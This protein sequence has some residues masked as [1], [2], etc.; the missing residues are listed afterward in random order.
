MERSFR[1]YILAGT[2]LAGSA[3]FGG[4]TPA[5]AG[6]TGA[7]PAV[8]YASL[9]CDLIITL[10][11]GGTATV[12][13]GP[14]HGL[15]GGTYDGV[16][17]TLIGLINDSGST[18]TAVKLTAK[19]DIF[20]FDGDGIEGNPNSTSGLPSFTGA[21]LPGTNTVACGATSISPNQGYCGTD[22]TN[23]NFNLSGPL[24]SFSGI[25]AAQDVGI[26]NFPGGI[27]NGG[28]AFWGL[29]EALTAASFTV[30]KPSVPE[31][32]TLSILG[33]ALAG[34]GMMRRRKQVT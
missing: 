1:Q 24:N 34:F 8:G 2:I 7:C 25:T 17:D 20:G 32:A 21:P 31:P 6:V 11:P 15:A 28:S 26:V 12:T 22:S 18:V 13:D 10:N 23:G 16:D 5:L 30:T 19:T 27:P 3:A 29:E 4:A 9:G 14:S 33:A